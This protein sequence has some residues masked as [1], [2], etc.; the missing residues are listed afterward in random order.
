M[1]RKKSALPE[2][3]A[4]L[5]ERDADERPLNILIAEDMEDNRLLIQCY[6][7]KTPHRLAIA[8]NG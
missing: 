8:E 6:F 3:E 7:K 2:E 4:Q 5:F 1:R